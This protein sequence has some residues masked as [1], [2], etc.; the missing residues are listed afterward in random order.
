MI[1]L[2][3][4]S[5]K[6]SKT[7]TR[8]SNRDLSAWA[9]GAEGAWMVPPRRIPHSIR[10]PMPHTAPPFKEVIGIII[11]ASVFFGMGLWRALTI[12]ANQ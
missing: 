12:A 11:A 3:L 10:A 2:L 8:W 1:P 6:M 5:P 4:P 9:D 7:K